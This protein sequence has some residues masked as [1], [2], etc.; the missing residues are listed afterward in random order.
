V[1]LLLGGEFS[2][3]GDAIGFLQ[4][5]FETVLDHWTAWHK[6]LGR[7]GLQ[8]RDVNDL[9][10]GMIAQKPLAMPPTRELLADAG[11]WTLH[12][13][14]SRLGGD[15]VSTV[16]YL[17]ERIG[18]VGVL[19]M[20]SHHPPH[21][22]VQLEISGPMGTLPLGGVRVLAAHCE[23][24]RWQ[25]HEYGEVRPFEHPDRYRSRRIRD[26]FDR[27]LLVQY[28]GALGIRVED[29]EFFGRAV[30]IVRAG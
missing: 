9:R 19:A 27:E 16:G 6:E 11:G 3:L 24:G 10:A 25:W 7:T 2:P 23:D 14:N 1:A 13:N 28:L 26:R 4:A 15:S 17:S 8:L 18:C 5:P 21:A 12:L 22:S 29:P 30:V 20:S